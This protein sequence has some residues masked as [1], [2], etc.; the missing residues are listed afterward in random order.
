MQHRFADV[1]HWNKRL[2]ET[3][4]V[5]RQHG[6]PRLMLSKDSVK[7]IRE[8]FQRTPHKFTGLP[9]AVGH[10]GAHIEIY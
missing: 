8:A 5:L 4:S 1:M 10:D 2:K 6:P 9:C 3:G 7:R